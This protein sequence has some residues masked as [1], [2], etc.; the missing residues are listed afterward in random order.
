MGITMSRAITVGSLADPIITHKIIMNDAT[1]VDFITVIRWETVIEIKGTR[2]HTKAR[3]TP[4][5]TPKTNPKKILKTDRE[6]LI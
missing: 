1:G 6:I 5:T 4:E 2:L 3:I